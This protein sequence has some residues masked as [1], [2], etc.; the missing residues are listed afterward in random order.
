MENDPYETTN[1]I[2]KYP[3]IAEE[4]MGFAEQHKAKFYPE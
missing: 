1:V 2:D 4:L 3:D